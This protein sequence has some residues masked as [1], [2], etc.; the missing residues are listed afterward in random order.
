MREAC[1][2]CQGIRVLKQDPLEALI[3]FICSSNNNIKRISLMMNRLCRHFGTHLCTYGGVEFY[4][5]PTLESLADGNAEST[6]RELGFGYRAK[7][8]SSAALYILENRSK[9]WLESLCHVD[10]HE[11]WDLL[12]EVPGVGPKV[13]DCVCLMG[14]GKY[15]AVPIDTHMI[16]VA[17]RQYG[18]KVPGKTLS[19]ITYKQIGNFY[20]IENEG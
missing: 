5:F 6:L 20:F 18:L 7:Y 13:A 15:E 19:K 2:A 3:A 8:V 9:D 16:Q 11:V 1:Q 12:Q 10:Y 17:M 14:L 4:S